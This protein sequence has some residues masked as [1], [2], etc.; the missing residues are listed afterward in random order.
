M[1]GISTRNF[2]QKQMVLR[3]GT[4]AQHLLFST[5]K[6]RVFSDK[7]RLFL[8]GVSTRHF[9]QAQMVLRGGNLKELEQGHVYA[10]LTDSMLSYHVLLSSALAA[11]L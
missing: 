8:H 2:V 9:C 3:G 1:H 4:A 5:E 11:V 6:I 10:L 7:N